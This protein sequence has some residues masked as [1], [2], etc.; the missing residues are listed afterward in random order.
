MSKIWV[1]IG[2]IVLALGVGPGL[3]VRAQAPDQ[4][5]T[6]TAEDVVL[7]NADAPITIFE[8]ASFTCP[9]CA[10]FDR[11]TLPMLKEAW[12]DTGKA[13]L[14]YRDFPL[15]EP[16]LHASVLARCAPPAMFYGFVDVLFRNQENWARAPDVD[17]AL[18]RLG[19]LGGLS[20]EKFDG[21]LR[22]QQFVNKILTER[23][24]ASQQY[25]VQSTPTFFINGRKLEGSLPY[26]EF[27]KALVAIASKS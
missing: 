9:H 22:D 13:R 1:S 23:L 4:A 18:G 10:D 7:G 25:G 15:D 2:L 21:C 20:G 5:P 26:A 14:I 12:I 3:P 19:K 17:A 27:D 24:Q 16:A 6:Q 8:Y 11:R